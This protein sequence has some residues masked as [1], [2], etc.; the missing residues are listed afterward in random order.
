[1]LPEAERGRCLDYSRFRECEKQA[2]RL[3]RRRIRGT[4]APDA[5]RSCRLSYVEGDAPLNLAPRPPRP[6]FF[7]KLNRRRGA[8]S[9]SFANPNIDVFDPVR[10][11]LGGIRR[12]RVSHQPI[13]V[14]FGRA[15]AVLLGDRCLV[16]RAFCSARLVLGPE[17]FGA[18]P[19]K[20]TAGKPAG[21]APLSRFSAGPPRG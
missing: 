16:S 10:L 15:A 14:H 19:R 3:P 20:P 2:G 7:P 8:I 6:E 9:R 1:M 21:S 11:D 12:D 5:P 17:L 13:F 4:F 18:A